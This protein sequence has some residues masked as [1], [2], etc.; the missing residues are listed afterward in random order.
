MA[1]G[2]GTGR[3][4][5]PRIGIPGDGPT[6]PRDSP[7]SPAHP[8]WP[9]RHAGTG[10]PGLDGNCSNLPVNQGPRRYV[11]RAWRWTGWAHPRHL[12][13]PGHW[14]SG[15]R[16]RGGPAVHQ[17]ARI[18]VA[19]LMIVL[20]QNVL[21]DHAGADARVAGAIVISG[22]CRSA[23]RW[24]RA[25][26]AAS[27]PV[28]LLWRNRGRSRWQAGRARDSRGRC[29]S[30]S[31]RGMPSAVKWSPWGSIVPDRPV[32]VSPMSSGR[33]WKAEA[34]EPL[35]VLRPD[36]PMSQK[37]DLVI[38]VVLSSKRNSTVRPLVTTSGRVA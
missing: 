25:P 26:Q 11:C 36:G 21:L 20:G 22:S 1:A 5:E 10:S 14:R 29:R 18:L 38:E 4:V 8:Q 6:C 15:T 23:S 19:I 31:V 34:K 2:V 16:H 32:P 35:G 13:P 12:A 3:F 17:V 7:R 28:P 24:R 30:N 33:G 9:S 27:A 37:L